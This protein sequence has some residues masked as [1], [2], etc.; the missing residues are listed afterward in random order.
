[1][2]LDSSQNCLTA[3]RN[4][5]FDAHRELLAVCLPST[6]PNEA[7]RSSRPSLIDLG[8]ASLV[9]TV[10]SLASLAAAPILNRAAP[11]NSAIQRILRAGAAHRQPSVSRILRRWASGGSS[12]GMSSLWSLSCRMVPALFGVLHW[13]GSMGGQCG[14]SGRGRLA[15]GSVSNGRQSALP[16]ASCGAVD[17][18]NSAFAGNGHQGQHWYKSGGDP[19]NVYI[20]HTCSCRQH[21]RLYKPLA[22]RQGR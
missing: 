11:R 14:S 2:R 16:G 3:I 1:V 5:H 6:Q 19:V 18:Y 22:L 15:G 10:L 21:H 9:Q 20:H 8:P 4:G 17:G 12:G 7:A 13:R